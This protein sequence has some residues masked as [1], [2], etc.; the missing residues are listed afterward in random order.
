M[1]LDKSIKYQ[2]IK[3]VS[4]LILFLMFLMIVIGYFT[5]KK[6]YS[7]VADD[8]SSELNHLYKNINSTISLTTT[9]I[10]DAKEN[11][12]KSFLENS[13][14]V[15][16]NLIKTE[17]NALYKNIKIISE[18]E[19][20][21]NAISFNLFRDKNI[22][23]DHSDYYQRYVIS[24]KPIK[25]ISI[26]NSEKTLAWPGRETRVGLELFNS[27][28]II[29]AR[30]DLKKEFREKNN[31][32]E[33]LSI[34]K[35]SLLP[36]INKIV[37]T[38][39]GLVIKVYSRIINPINYRASGGLIGTFPIDNTFI[40]H[41]KE[42]TNC[43]IIVFR[44]Y[45]VYDTTT[46]YNG[47]ERYNFPNKTVIFEDIKNHPNKIIFEDML[48]KTSLKDNP[49]NITFKSYKFIYYP[50]L[51]DEQNIV[52]MIALGIQ[53]DDFKNMVSSL[54]K[55]EQNTF[56]KFS[57]SKNE[58]V[59]NVYKNGKLIITS[60]IYIITIIMILGGFI[61]LILLDLYIRN[62]IIKNLNYFTEKIQNL[63]QNYNE[64]TPIEVIGEDEIGEL[65]KIFNEFID[66]LNRVKQQNII[67]IHNLTDEL[68]KLKT[69]SNENID[70]ITENSILIDNIYTDISNKKEIYEKNYDNFLENLNYTKSNI[71]LK[72]EN[73]KINRELLKTG[74]LNL[75]D[76]INNNLDMKNKINYKQSE[77]L[78]IKYNENL[79]TEISEFEKLNITQYEQISYKINLF[80]D[81]LCK[82]LVYLEKLEKIHKINNNIHYD[83]VK[84]IKEFMNE[85]NEFE[86]TLK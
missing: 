19:N 20:I 35:T 75:V 12:L 64:L 69:K 79:S 36:N 84:N 2:L 5:I 56:N 74:F 85:I 68:H 78:F 9:E 40:R 58:I 38:D 47:K 7:S 46:I 1:K 86:K 61:V 42:S 53:I 44:D 25:Y 49:S 22:R 33:I 29:K 6:K 41:V 55:D 59:N 21:Q 81:E 72:Y 27:N 60:Y 30:T 45:G 63:S 16:D 66:N 83:Y 8:L 71:K 4:L 15:C 54:L 3:F 18:K 39:K 80:H 24:E 62:I 70:N 28:G 77:I 50:I 43:E 13:A 52:G 48:I 10:R 32:N 57:K 65:M 26:L 23:R 76:L 17:I 11:E 51:N 67:A 14:R 82:I 73:I 34:L 37:S 31:S